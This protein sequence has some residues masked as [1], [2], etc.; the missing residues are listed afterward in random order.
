MVQNV[1]NTRNLQPGGHHGVI[2]YVCKQNGHVLVRL[3]VEISG[4][5]TSDFELGIGDLLEGFLKGNWSVF[6]VLGDVLG[7]GSFDFA[8]DVVRND[9]G[10]EVVLSKKKFGDCV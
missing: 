5:K 3:D 9:A 4:N 10:H 7:Q 6:S 2:D 1:Q 8:Y